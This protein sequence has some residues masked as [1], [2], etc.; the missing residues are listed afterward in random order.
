MWI[1]WLSP[2]GGE[3]SWRSVH[4]AAPG[5]KGMGFS[6][7]AVRG[8]G[9]FPSSA[10]SLRAEQRKSEVVLVLMTGLAKGPSCR[11][12]RSARPL[13]VPSAAVPH[14]LSISAARRCLCAPSP[15]LTHTPARSSASSS[16]GWWDLCRENVREKKGSNHSCACETGTAPA[17]TFTQK[18]AKDEQGFCG[19]KLQ[20]A[21]CCSLTE[22]SL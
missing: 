10:Q 8:L 20:L 22:I 7:A 11:Q 9:A 14:G 12:A 2:R 13:C 18:P 1:W 3:S 16:C 6:G 4:V 15:H 17:L 5:A 19:Q 21:Y